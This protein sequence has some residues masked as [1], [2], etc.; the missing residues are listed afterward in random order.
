METTPRIDQL[1]GHAHAIAFTAEA[2]FENVLHPEFLRDFF[3]VRFRPFESKG[4]SACDHLQAFDF[5]EH[6]QD[7]FA[8]SIAKIFLILRRAQIDE[9]EDGDAFFRGNRR[10]RN[11]DRSER[12]HNFIKARIGP[13]RIEKWV[14]TQTSIVH[15]GV[16]RAG[17]P[18]RHRQLF[19]GEV[20]FANP[21][22]DDREKLDHQRTSGRVFNK[23]HQLNRAATFSQSVFLSPEAGVDQSKRANCRSVVWLF[24]HQTLLLLTRARK[25]E[26]RRGLVDT[27]AREQALE[28]FVIQHNRP[29]PNRSTGKRYHRAPRAH[30]IPF[31]ERPI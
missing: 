24:P 7:F 27:H 3:H 10:R 25:G 6:V 15:P 29:D 5:R 13:K 30:E 12:G 11:R 4:R 31:A 28:K 19:E 21:P 22:A 26:L 16:H 17:K 23:R 2:A 18:G 1:R 20:E 9:R 8:D 14:E